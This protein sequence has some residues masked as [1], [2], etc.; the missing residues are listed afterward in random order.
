MIEIQY[1]FFKS[2]LLKNNFR[3]KNIKRSGVV[4]NEVRKQFFFG[5]HT[6]V[7]GYTV[8]FRPGFITLDCR[9]IGN[10]QLHHRSRLFILIHSLP[11]VQ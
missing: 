7:Q 10:S 9:L 5:S 11:Y 3:R 6:N 1:V 4:S 2:K 8:I